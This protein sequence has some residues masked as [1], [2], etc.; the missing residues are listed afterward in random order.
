VRVG[1]VAGAGQFTRSPNSAP[2]IDTSTA[3]SWRPAGVSPIAWPFD[4][5][6]RLIESLVC[7]V[8]ILNATLCYIRLG[9]GSQ[10]DVVELRLSDRSLGE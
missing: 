10:L 8:Q 5:G 4:V 2:A 6:H 9:N 7:G 3:P 1:E